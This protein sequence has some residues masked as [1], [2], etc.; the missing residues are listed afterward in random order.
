MVRNKVTG[1]RHRE[2]VSKAKW[3][4]GAPLRRLR[5]AEARAEVW[6]SE[7]ANCEPDHAKSHP[8]ES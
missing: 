5:E 3:D 2:V 6:P 1:P 8:S 7:I 4:G